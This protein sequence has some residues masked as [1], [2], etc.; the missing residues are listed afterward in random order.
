MRK[1]IACGSWSAG[2]GVKRRNSTLAIAFEDTHKDSFTVKGKEQTLPQGG[3][4]KN[5]IVI[6]TQTSL[7]SATNLGQV[8]T[9]ESSGG[10][11]ISKA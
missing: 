6:M 10:P 9:Q 2:F 8:S 1:G 5:A 4:L 7:N 11:L 3:V